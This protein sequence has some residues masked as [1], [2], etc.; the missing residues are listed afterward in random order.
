MA[1]LIEAP[2]VMTGQGWPDYGLLDS[3]HGRKL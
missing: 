3:G 2:V 1:E